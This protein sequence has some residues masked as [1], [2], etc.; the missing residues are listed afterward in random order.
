VTAARRRAAAAGQ[1]GLGLLEVLAAI[2]IFGTGAA[3][4]FGWIGQTATRLAVLE[5][6]QQRLFRALAAIEYARSVNPMLQPQG[7]V[8]LG[9]VNVRWT[10][11]PVGEQAPTRTLSGTRGLYVVSLYE[12]TLRSETPQGGKSEITVMQAGWRQVREVS[13]NTPFALDAK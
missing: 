8:V 11:R 9:D 3:I 13:T 1:R 6:E 10:S 5:S 2:V 7:E 4:L 12:L